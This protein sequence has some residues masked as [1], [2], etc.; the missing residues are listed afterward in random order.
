MVPKLDDLGSISDFSIFLRKFSQKFSQNFFLT[1]RNG[2]FGFE[3]STTNYKLANETKILAFSQIFL[4]FDFFLGF[5]FSGWGIRVRLLA[6][7]R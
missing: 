5:G 6:K 2:G 7:A 1:G 3:L 4:I